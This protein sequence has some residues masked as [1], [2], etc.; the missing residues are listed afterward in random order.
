M[1][2]AGV[3]GFAAM[4]EAGLGREKSWGWD[5]MDWDEIHEHLIRDEGREIPGPKP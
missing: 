2:Q 1:G 5:D 3:V 4:A